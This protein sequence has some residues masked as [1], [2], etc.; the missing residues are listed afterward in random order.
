MLTGRDGVN[1][2]AQGCVLA[3]RIV[4]RLV[5]YMLGISGAQGG[6]SEGND[7]EGILIGRVKRW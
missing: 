7:S 1:K 3:T 5:P 6:V 4:S 2:G